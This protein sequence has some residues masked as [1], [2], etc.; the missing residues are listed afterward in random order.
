MISA[1]QPF[2]AHLKCGLYSFMSQIQWSGYLEFDN[3]PDL[4][5]HFSASS[6]PSILT[7]STSFLDLL[8]V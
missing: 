5:A 1:L 4:Y 3:P 7:F 8:N 2:S 6:L